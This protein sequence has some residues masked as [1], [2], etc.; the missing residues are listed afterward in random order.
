[1]SLGLPDMVSSAGHP[2]ESSCDVQMPV[3]FECFQPNPTVTWADA[4]D[5]TVAYVLVF[6]DP[7]AGDY[8]H[9]AIVNI[10]AAEG[11]LDAGISGEAITNTPAGRGL[12]AGQRLWVERLPRVMPAGSPHLPVAAGAVSE[13]LPEGL[14]LLRRRRRPPMRWPSPRP[15]PATS[16]GPA[17]LADPPTC[18]A[19]PWAGTDATRTHRA[20]RWHAVILVI[21]MVVYGA[22]WAAP[23]WTQLH[24]RSGAKDHASFHYAVQAAAAGQDPYDAAGLQ[25]LAEA[26]GVQTEVYPRIYPPPALLAFSWTLPLDFR[27]SQSV[28]WVLNH[29]ALAGLLVLLRRWFAPPLFLLGATLAL[30][31]RSSRASAWA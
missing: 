4:P 28:G 6:D 14:G 29:V 16:T 1:M 9:W 17:P 20:P 25:A 8:P 18:G 11:G 19:A 10:P 7:D 27:L 31:T 30:F 13:A 12:R 2:L 26:D 3:E 15:A 22:A 24:R 5:G 21:G 23:S